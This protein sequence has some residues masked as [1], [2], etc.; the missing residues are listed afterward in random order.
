MLF[1]VLFFAIKLEEYNINIAEFCSK[2]QGCT[3]EIIIK[4]EYVLLRALKYDLTVLSPF[5][6]IKSLL[7]KMAP[8]NLDAFI[9]AANQYLI[10]CFKSDALYLYSP[11]IL[12]LACAKYALKK[13]LDVKAVD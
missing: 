9:K 12:A 13:K 2:V 7:T 6:G 3:E 8:S 10:R 11:S 5:R 4:Y 1:V